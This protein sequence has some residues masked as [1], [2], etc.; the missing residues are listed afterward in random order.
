MLLF[1]LRGAEDDSTTAAMAA[2]LE[3]AAVETLFRRETRWAG[4]REEDK[5][6][7]VLACE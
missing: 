6:L 4:L 3:A 1:V 7:E 5:E 2:T